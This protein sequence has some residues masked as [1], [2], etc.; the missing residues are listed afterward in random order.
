MRPKLHEI[1][2]RATID[3]GV[4]VRLG[5]RVT[6]ISDERDDTIV[7]FSDGSSAHYGLIVG[8]DGANSRPLAFMMFPDAPAPKFTGQGSWKTTTRRPSDMSSLEVYLGAT[9]K[10]GLVPVSSTHMYMFTLSPE[11]GD[12][13]YPPESWPDRLSEVLTGFGGRIAAIRDNLQSENTI[14]Y[15]PL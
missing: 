4:Q 9:V 2:A 5:V 14:V 13:F 6:E 8:A 3:S 1:L 10:A 12:P 11:P 7:S 15:R